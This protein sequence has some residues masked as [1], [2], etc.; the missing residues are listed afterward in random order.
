MS[1][2]WTRTWPG[3]HFDAICTEYVLNK[4]E[5]KER[6]KLKKIKCNHGALV[7]MANVSQQ[8]LC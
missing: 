2:N 5:K 4:F 3:L 7:G 8:E 6:K 1:W